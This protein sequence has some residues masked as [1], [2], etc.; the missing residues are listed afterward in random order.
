MISYYVIL[1]IY[2]IVQFSPIFHNSK[3][4]YIQCDNTYN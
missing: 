4:I 1:E 2:K 3:V